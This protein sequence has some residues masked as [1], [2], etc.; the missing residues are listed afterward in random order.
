M[1]RLDGSETLREVRR[2]IPD[3]PV[4]LM[5]GHSEQELSGH[6]AGQN[7]AGFLHKPFTLETVRQRLRQVLAFDP[8]SQ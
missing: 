2:L 5:S 4:I 1:P 3:L 7:V 8:R 6:F